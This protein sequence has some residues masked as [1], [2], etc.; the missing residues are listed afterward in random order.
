MQQRK[1]RHCCRSLP[2]SSPYMTRAHPSPPKLSS[3]EIGAALVFSG[4]GSA[5]VLQMRNLANS[6]KPNTQPQLAKKLDIS[7]LVLSWMNVVV[8]RCCVCGSLCVANKQTNPPKGYPAHQPRANPPT[9]TT[10]RTTVPYQAKQKRGN[11]FLAQNSLNGYGI[12]SSSYA[13]TRPPASQLA[14]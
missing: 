1:L 7:C 9:A 3:S 14:T 10:S 4:R 11:V 12:T 8:R 5:C 2:R 13:T 6:R